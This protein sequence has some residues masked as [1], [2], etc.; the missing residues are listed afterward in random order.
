[1][2]DKGYT[3]DVDLM[4]E[5]VPQMNII[6]DIL[7][8]SSNMAFALTSRKL[9]LSYLAT[10]RILMIQLHLFSLIKNT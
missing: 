9:K 2:T 5:T 6:L 4:S 10:T 7:I 1:M 3:D 8:E